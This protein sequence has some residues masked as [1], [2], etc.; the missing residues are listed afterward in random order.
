MSEGSAQPAGPAIKRTDAE[1]EAM[2]TTARGLANTAVTGAGTLGMK[3]HAEGV[4]L[5]IAWM[6]GQD[7]DPLDDLASPGTN[8]S[9][10]FSL[11]VQFP[12]GR[13]A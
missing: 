4:L 9:L 7:L 11:P 6:L 8:L 2:M 1:V 13:S 3:C 10:P 12:A 5:A